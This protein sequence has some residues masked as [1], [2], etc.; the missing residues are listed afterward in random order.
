MLNALSLILAG[1]AF[2]LGL[3]MCLSVLAASPLDVGGAILLLALSVLVGSPV[4]VTIRS[5]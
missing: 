2:L 5:G 4:L 1:V 3:L